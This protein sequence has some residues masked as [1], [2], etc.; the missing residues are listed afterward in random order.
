MELIILILSIFI[1]SLTK[2]NKLILFQIFKT[3]K[4][5]KDNINQI[6]LEFHHAHL[7]DTTKEKFHKILE[8]LSNIFT[9]VDFRKDPKG[10][11]VSIIYCRK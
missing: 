4:L 6:I 10:A 1:A 5:I 3:Y 9:N 7:N 2:F 8:L 11:W